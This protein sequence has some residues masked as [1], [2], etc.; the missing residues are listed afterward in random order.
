MRHR[1]LT[2]GRYGESAV[3]PRLFGNAQERR[4]WLKKLAVRMP[5]EPWL[6][7]AYHYLVRL[8][9]LEGR[10][11]LIACRLRAQYI[12]DV[13]AKLYELARGRR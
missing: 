7:F 5:F 3:T 11:G 1:F 13:R 2:T 12:T 9:F 8:G 10:R 4:R 6:W